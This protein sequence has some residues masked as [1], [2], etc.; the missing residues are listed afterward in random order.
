MPSSSHT[1]Q[2]CLS[3]KHDRSRRTQVKQGPS[4]TMSQYIIY[5]AT[6]EGIVVVQHLFTRW[7][8]SVSLC[9]IYQRIL[10]YV[11]HEVRIDRLGVHL[12]EESHYQ[13][14]V[15][16]S[17]VSSSTLRANLWE[18]FCIIQINNPDE[19]EC[20]TECNS[21]KNRQVVILS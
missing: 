17:L 18:Y 2:F 5:R 10:Y 12:H 19:G 8:I 9:A 20:S 15:V 4:L 13:H 21:M 16:V 7:C 6:E 3:Q 14:G 11:R 1:S